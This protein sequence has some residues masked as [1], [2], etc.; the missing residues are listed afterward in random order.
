MSGQYTL[1]A[2]LDLRHAAPDVIDAFADRLLE[3][4]RDNETVGD[5]TVDGALAGGWLAVAF[6]MRA[7]SR[8]EAEAVLGDA[9][10]KAI[11]AAADPLAA[12]HVV[13]A[14]RTDLVEA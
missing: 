6:T 13:R 3:A 10:R 8:R 9:L 1:Q 2:E 4:L 14:V 5:A 7:P 12:L 11:D